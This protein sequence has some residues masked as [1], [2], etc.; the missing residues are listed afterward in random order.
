M[1]L[2]SCSSSVDKATDS[3]PWGPR[4]ESTGSSSS[5]LGQGTLSSLPSPSER[6]LIH[7][8]MYVYAPCNQWVAISIYSQ[9]SKFNL[10][11]KFNN[12]HR[13]WSAGHRGRPA[14][15]VW[16]APGSACSRQGK[17]WKGLAGGLVL[18][19]LKSYRRATQQHVFRIFGWYSQKVTTCN[20]SQW[21]TLEF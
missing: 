12:S 1:N 19:V 4:F 20:F 9:I 16:S 21:L 17:K 2:R 13:L 8:Y 10:S 15:C 5:A 6:T 3:Q 18:G 14:R 11:N 7:W